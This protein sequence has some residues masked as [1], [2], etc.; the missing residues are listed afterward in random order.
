[1]GG[2]FAI[3]NDFSQIITFTNLALGLLKA[4]GLFEWAG[5]EL[6]LIG[7]GWWGVFVAWWQFQITRPGGLVLRTPRLIEPPTGFGRWG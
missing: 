1:M 7:F 5:W 6:A 4:V 2:F 3:L